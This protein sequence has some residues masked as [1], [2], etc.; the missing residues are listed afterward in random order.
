VKFV[1]MVISVLRDCNML[2]WDKS[3][4]VLATFSTAAGGQIETGWDTPD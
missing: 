3:L 1:K 2:L 4:A